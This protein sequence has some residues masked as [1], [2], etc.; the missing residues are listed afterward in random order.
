MLNVNYLRFYKILRRPFLRLL[1]KLNYEITEV[2][3]SYL[4]VPNLPYTILYRMAWVKI[5]KT[6]TS[7]NFWKSSFIFTINGKRIFVQLKIPKFGFSTSTAFSAIGKM[8]NRT[9]LMV[10]N[11]AYYIFG[12]NLFLH[13]NIWISID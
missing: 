2:W 5:T 4:T 12:L 6:I 8:F 3:Q 13:R 10:T 7:I 1:K 9:I 11:I